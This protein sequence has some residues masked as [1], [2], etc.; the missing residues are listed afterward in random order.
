MILGKFIIP[1]PAVKKIILLLKRRP[2]AGIFLNPFVLA[3]PFTLLIFHFLPIDYTKYKVDFIE[4]RFSQ[5][6]DFYHDLDFDGNSERISFRYEDKKKMLGSFIIFYDDYEGHK[7]IDQV[8]FDVNFVERAKPIF[9]DFDNDSLCETYFFLKNDTSLFIAAVE[10]S[11]TNHNLNTFTNKFVNRIY[12]KNMVEDFY[13]INGPSA[14]LNGDGYKEIIFAI[15][16][17][18]SA[19]PREVCAYDVK[20]DSIFRS[21]ESAICFQPDIQFLQVGLDKR[22]WILTIN[23][24]T[25]TNY[26]G[27]K[28]ICDDSCGWAFGLNENL[29]FLFDPVPNKIGYGYRVEN[30]PYSD[31]KEA[32]IISLFMKPQGSLGNTKLVKYSLDG[33]K[34]KEKVLDAKGRYAIFN[35]DTKPGGL[36]WLCRYSPPIISLMNNDLEIIETMD[37]EY[38]I[39]LHRHDLSFYTMDLN[40]D[41][42]REIILTHLSDKVVIYSSKFTD[43][44]TIPVKV[45]QRDN[46]IQR[47]ISSTS[48]WPI[49]MIKSG[50]HQLMYTYRK[51]SLFYWKYLI[52]AGLYLLSML[53]FY[54][55]LKLQKQIMLRR[56]ETEKQLYYHQMLSIKNQ[57]DPHFTLNAINNISAM[58]ISGRNEEANRFLTKFS[59]LI[60][61]SLMDSDKIESTIEEELRFV[62]DYLDVQKI[63]F[64]DTFDYTITFSNNGLKTV[65]IPRQLIHTFVENAIK[66]GLRPKETRSLLRI[67]VCEQNSKIQIEID[68]NGVGRQADVKVESTGKGISIVKQI[69]TLYE[70]LQGKKVSYEVIDKKDES[71]KASGTRVEISIPKDPMKDKRT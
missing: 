66:H 67:S 1:M 25:T 52:F 57:V 64:K 28:D 69:I 17:L 39:P 59:R 11:T 34:L 36:F 56:Y 55:L 23:T 71:G 70:K 54:Y 58:Y 18:Y 3:I 21:P 62:T 68:D 65:K 63:R 10:Y 30:L 50:D 6:N 16:G 49:L 26:K 15:Y 13:I 38:P 45:E 33:E 9:C 40:G 61:R 42:K 27:D 12:H 14:D 32:G 5:S 7:V 22:Q 44:V 31:Q 48:A 4:E 20:N 43:P 24:S 8:N 29:Y 19:K 41:S 51:N 2:L 47:I 35:H 60:H 37:L 53:F 46:D